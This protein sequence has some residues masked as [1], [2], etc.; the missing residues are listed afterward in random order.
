MRNFPSIL[1]TETA[2]FTSEDNDLNVWAD[3]RKFV[4]QSKGTANIFSY[5]TD[6]DYV[7][8]EMKLTVGY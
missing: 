8:L 7:T 1:K 6:L 3:V 4:K 5:M 2:G